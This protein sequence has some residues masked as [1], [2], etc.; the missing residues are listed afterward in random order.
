MLINTDTDHQRT[1]LA[2]ADQ[3]IRRM[4]LHHCQRKG[5]IKAFSDGIDRFWQRL[6]GTQLAID[7]M[8]HHLSVCLGRK[9]ITRRFQLITQRFMILDDAIVHD[10]NTLVGQMRVRVVLC[11]TPVSR[12]A[13]M[14]HAD[15][16]TQWRVKQDFFQR[17]YL[18]YRPCTT[19]F[20]AWIDHGDACRVIATVFE[21][22]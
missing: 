19:Q 17:T 2:R 4:L 6:A 12:P 7:Q 16:A 18:A 3:Q 1:A 15:G 22:M 11:R 14:C 5:A 10:R 13:G 8:C 21:A 9:G 20:A